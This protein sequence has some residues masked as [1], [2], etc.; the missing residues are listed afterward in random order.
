MS[1]PLAAMVVNECQHTVE[2]LRAE[3]ARLNSALAQHSA[4]REQALKERDA[5]IEYRNATV[6]ELQQAHRSAA[7][8][9]EIAEQF[10][11]EL[12]AVRV[13]GW[14][15]SPALAAKYV[16]T[17]EQALNSESL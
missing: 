3:V 2:V 8:Q 10:G 11:N 1:D 13:S 14:V 9:H 15:Y 12:R 4:E 6:Q 5:A 7:S 16:Q 17:H